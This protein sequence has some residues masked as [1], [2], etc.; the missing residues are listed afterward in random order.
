MVLPVLRVFG[1]LMR[2]L[3]RPLSRGL[4]LLLTKRKLAHTLFERLGQRANQFEAYLEF[5]AAH[6]DE[7]YSRQQLG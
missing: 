1:L 2:M 5:K 3:S 6:P 4:T 7:R